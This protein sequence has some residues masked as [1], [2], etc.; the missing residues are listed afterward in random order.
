MALVCCCALAG[1]EACK[2]CA[3]YKREFGNDPGLNHT[4]PWWP[5]TQPWIEPQPIPITPTWPET[6]PYEPYV[7]PTVPLWPGVN[8]P[9]AADPKRI[10]IDKD[11]IKRIYT[12][13]KKIIIELE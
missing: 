12:E 11:K 1:T 6:Q 8:Q 2:N 13:G 7:P 4:Q 10:E 3:T 5:N 9:P